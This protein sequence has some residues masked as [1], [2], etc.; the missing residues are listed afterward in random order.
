MVAWAAASSMVGARSQ[1]ACFQHNGFLYVLG[2]LTD[3][4]NNG[5]AVSTTEYVAVNADGSLGTWANTTAL[6]AA[7]RAMGVAVHKAH[8]RVYIVGGNDSAGTIL[9]TVQWAPINGDGTL[10]SWTTTTVLPGNRSFVA[11]A[12]VGNTLYAIAGNSS[13]TATTTTVYRATI[14][15]GT[16]NIGAWTTGGTAFPFSHRGGSVAT[17]GTKIYV[18][19]GEALNPSVENNTVYYADA[20]AEGNLTW[21]LGSRL[22]ARGK[23]GITLVN[24]N[25]L[26]YHQYA[27]LMTADASS[28]LAAFDITTQPVPTTVFFAQGAF[29]GLRMYR[30]GGTAVAADGTIDN[31]AVSTVY[32][33][34]DA[35]YGT[36]ALSKTLGALTS[37]A[38]GQ[39]E[40][41][42]ALVKTLA[43]TVLNSFTA[44]DTS[45]PEI[46]NISPAPGTA[47]SR[48]TPLEIEVVDDQDLRN[49]A[50][51]V[52]YPGD[53][54]VELVYDGGKFRGLYRELPN[55]VNPIAGGYR[56]KILRLGGWPNSPTLEYAV[57]DTGGN[58]GVIDA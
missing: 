51:W 23:M 49:I 54:T 22:P 50:L 55:A 42:G 10:G 24:G 28:G 26:L 18:I 47:I 38:A 48:N 29:E 2:G 17:V 35:A 34:L 30:T 58:L 53:E 25:Q 40:V 43:N 3:T 52:S 1:H 39:A 20:V 36:G 19:G 56:F 46:Q 41:Q 11:A 4:T 12:I 13:A 5:S 37:S 27:E 9:T 15:T 31:N 33:N 45:P 57:V 21:T 8:N 6:T 32:Y 14:N 7:R 16:G 44:A